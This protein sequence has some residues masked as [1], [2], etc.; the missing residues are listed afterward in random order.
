MISIKHKITTLVLIGTIITLMRTRFKS[1]IGAVV[2]CVICI[3]YILQF[4]GP[5]K[6]ESVSDKN[7]QC[8]IGNTKQ[9]GGLLE[10]GCL[11]IWMIYHVIFWIVL[12]L[13][14]PN[15]FLLAFI[16]GISWEIVEHITFKHISKTCTTTTCGRV[17]DVFLNMLG[18]AI[19]SYLS[20]LRVI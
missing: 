2:A 19:G 15:R 17:E 11:D 20:T 16:I 9:T 10:N 3:L 7:K 8:L 6:V 1:D 5:K 12:G 14:S 13:L 4:F 18:Y